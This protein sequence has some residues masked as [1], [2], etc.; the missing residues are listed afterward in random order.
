MCVCAGYYG[1]TK[2]GME[3]EFP[4][5]LWR[6]KFTTKEAVKK[7]F[8]LSKREEPR[9]VDKSLDIPAEI[10]EESCV[11]FLFYREAEWRWMG[12]C[13][14]SFFIKAIKEPFSAALSEVI[15]QFPSF[16]SSFYS[17]SCFATTID[18]QLSR[19]AIEHLIDRYIVVSPPNDANRSHW[20]M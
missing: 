13:V 16:S 7:S 14:A 12:N 10:Y 4:R 20:Q 18:C 5:I 9:I 2:L 15:K 8:M 11:V 6:E 3:K 19:K 1:T 17:F